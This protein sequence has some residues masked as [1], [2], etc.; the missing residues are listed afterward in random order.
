MQALSDYV[1][2]ICVAFSSPDRENIRQ[3]LQEAVRS[4]IEVEDAQFQNFDYSVDLSLVY[5]VAPLTVQ[6]IQTVVS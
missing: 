1:L 5:K 2:I 3:R 4:D 6:Q